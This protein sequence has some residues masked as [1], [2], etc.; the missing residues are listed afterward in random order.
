MLVLSWADL[1]KIAEDA[2]NAGKPQQIFL[3]YPYGAAHAPS[4]SACQPELSAKYP[5]VSFRVPSGRDVS[6]HIFKNIAH[7]IAVSGVCVFDVTGSNPNVFVELG[8]AIALGK[9]VKIMRAAGETA[10][11]PSD[12]QGQHYSEFTSDR[13][14]ADQLDTFLG[15]YYRPKHGRWDEQTIK[16]RLRVQLHRRSGPLD[17][18]DAK[19][20]TLADGINCDDRGLVR[21]VLKN[22]PSEFCRDPKTDRWFLL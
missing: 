13:D 5:G 4:W 20:D 19:A 21:N 11:L 12:M 8:F 22:H 18:Y 9:I 16:K 1:D 3:G 17:V 6:G 10:P 15:T 14:L 7:D 2:F